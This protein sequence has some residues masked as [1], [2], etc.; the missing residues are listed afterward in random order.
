M[1]VCESG[2]VCVFYNPKYFK[3]FV[4]ISREAV[5]PLHGPCRRVVAMMMMMVMVMVLGMVVARWQGDYAFYYPIKSDSRVVCRLVALCVPLR[6][7]IRR[8]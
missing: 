7:D 4:C 3:R 8:W 6:C 5:C 1:S 2:S